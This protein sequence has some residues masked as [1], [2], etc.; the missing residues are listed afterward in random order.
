MSNQT[1]FASAYADHERVTLTCNDPSLAKQSMADECDVNQIMARY[2]KSGIVDHVN[3][4]Q[5]EYGDFTGVQS[6][7]ESIEQ[8]Q[9]ATEAFMTLPARIRS[10]FENDPGK[11]LEFATDPKNL[12]QMREYG[13][14]KTERPAQPEP[15]PELELE[16]GEAAPAA[17]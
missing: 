9:N 12:P 11:F 8:V 17:D 7:Q 15:T 10:D 5:G 13:L 16:P 14:A 2:E 1:K 4:F 3:Q 6:F